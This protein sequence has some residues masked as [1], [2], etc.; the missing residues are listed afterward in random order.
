MF[1]AG[2]KIA[3]RN[4]AGL[5]I[6]DDFI[7]FAEINEE[8]EESRI[9]SA[10]LPEGCVVNGA[11][12]DFTMLEE[13]FKAIRRKTGK[14]REPV[15]I[16]L[17]YGDTII[18]RPTQMPK[19][20]IDDIRSTME[21]NFEDYFTTRTDTVF[22]AVIIK[23]P[24]DASDKEKVSVLAATA[25]KS[26]VDKIL[27]IAKKAEIPAGAIE[28]VNFA[29]LRSVKNPQGLCIF[30]DSHNTVA[31]WD[32]YGIFFR[33]SNN[34][35]GFSD[36][37]NT[38]QFLRTQ[39][40][41]AELNEIILAGL[42]FQ[43][44]TDSGLSIINIDDPYYSAKGLALRDSPEEG[45]DLRP[46]EYVELERR[47]YSFNPNRLILWGLLG[48]F[49]MMT[50]GVVSYAFLNIHKLS[51]MID[52]MSENVSQLTLQR[53]TLERKNAEL[54]NATKQTQKIL[55]FLKGDIPVLEILNALEQNQAAGIKFDNADF[56]AST[57]GGYRVTLDGKAVDERAVITMTSGLKQNE[58]FS[59]VV[60][61]F[62]QKDQL[63]RIV[64]KLILSVKDILVM[65]AG[66]SAHG[67]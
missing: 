37:L 21:L 25:K 22:D 59:N 19:M 53:Q 60:L 51:S 49:L 8:G 50:M 9:A 55:D 17:P 40:R 47:R 28:P 18:R 65:R 57:L 35:N 54:E 36:I 3:Q 27:E 5:A 48:G 41:H 1:G 26:L 30:A 10:A 67:K 52:D 7:H 61:P 38:G 33:T 64:F 31:L 2:K 32:G 23:T 4:Y 11:I 29:M 12:K 46:H 6:H 39:Y 63:Q 15:T 42:D 66:D 43:I 58:I 13:A 62:S 34:V 45:L 44:S 24:A 16:G 14:I 20:S 56:S